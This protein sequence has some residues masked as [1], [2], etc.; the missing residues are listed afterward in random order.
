MSKICVVIPVYNEFSAI[1]R[2]VS[3]IRGKGLDVIVIDD[4]SS[5]GSGQKAREQGAIVLTHNIRQGKGTS[6]KH[7][8]EYALVHDYDGVLTMDGDGQHDPEDIDQFLNKIRVIPEGV[9]TGNRFHNSRGMP[10]V[11]RLTN[12]LMSVL[13]SGLCSQRIPDT[14]CGF[15]YISR[16][17]LSRVR[18]TSHDFEIETEVL[19][20]ATRNGYK[21][22][23]V[24]VKTIYE[25]EKSKI[26]P[27]K[28]TLKFI[29]YYVKALRSLWA[30]KKHKDYK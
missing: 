14:Q 11:R 29:V 24:P 6:L 28:D 7:G 18:L 2:I 23:S 8:F 15:R 4:G 16:E 12:Q 26:N 30:T 13:I 27:F 17:I 21:I 1:G 25:D 9:I 5:D 10:L 22:Y 20:E 3:G 19:V